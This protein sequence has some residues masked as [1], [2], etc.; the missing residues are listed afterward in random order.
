MKEI[1]RLTIRAEERA[2]RM[3]ERKRMAI[4]VER[5]SRD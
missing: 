1:K 5:E 4:K 2:E 3:N